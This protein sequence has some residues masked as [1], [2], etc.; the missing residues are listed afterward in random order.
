M[1]DVRG[2]TV[3]DQRCF[4]VSCEPGLVIVR[5]FGEID[6]RQSQMWRDR[7]TAEI[8]LRGAPRFVAFDMIDAHPK[9][10]MKTRFEVA[11]YCRDLMKR[12][13][14]AALLLPVSVGGALV[15]RIV[16][17]IVATS[18]ISVVASRPE[19]DAVLASMRRG[20]RPKG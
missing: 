5:L 3:A 2:E 14:W 7:L 6:D 8:Q 11:A 18:R 20:D 4:D 19:L 12:V 13:E 17:S 1:P 10:S 15:V 9:N 16:I